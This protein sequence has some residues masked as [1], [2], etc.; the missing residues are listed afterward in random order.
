MKPQTVY[1]VLA[2]LG[3]YHDARATRYKELEKASADPRA[4][5]LLHHLVDLERQ[6]AKVIRLEMERLPR[7]H[8]TYLLTGPTISPAAMH[9]ADC[10]CESSSS[11]E[12]IL[13]CAM[14]CDE[15]LEELLD[16]IEDCSA[17]TSIGELAKRLRELEMTKCREIAKFTRED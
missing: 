13:R 4:D 9:V 11:F 17:A 8:S 7:E 6:S 3:E 15:R 16:R 5:I 10:R 2:L 12:D 1:D 14:T